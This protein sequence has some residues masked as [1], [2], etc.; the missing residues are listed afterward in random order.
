VPHLIESFWTE[1]I[2]NIGPPAPDCTCPCL[3]S[4]PISWMPHLMDPPFYRHPISWMP[5]IIDGPSYWIFLNSI[6]IKHRTSHTWLHMSMLTILSHLMDAPYHREPILL[7]HPSWI[8]IKHR[9]SRS[10]LHM[11]ML[12]IL[13]HLMDAP[14]YGSSILWTSHL[15]NVSSHRCPILMNLSKLNQY[16]TSDLPL[17][18]SQVHAYY[19]IPSHGCL[20]P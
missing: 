3:L 7:N 6:N 16:K 4:Y 1:S 17:L 14:S 11:S 18:I 5:H 2:S 20:I 8:N 19:L 13:S 10:W 9:T 12:T 15:M